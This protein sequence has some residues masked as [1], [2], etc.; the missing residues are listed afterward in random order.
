LGKR[1]HNAILVVS[2]PMSTYLERERAR[3]CQLIVNDP[4][5]FDGAIGGRAFVGAPRPFVLIEQDRNLFSAIRNN[6][7]SYFASNRISWWGGTR[8]TGHT[9]SSQVA[10]VNHMFAWRDDEAAATAV[11]RAISTEFVRALPIASDV[12]VAGF[13]QFEAVSDHQ[14]LNEGG[15]TRGTQCTSVD[16]MMYAER[17]DGSRWLVPIEWKYTEHYGNENKAAAGV[18][19]D[20]I[21]GKGAVRQRRYN[22]LIADSDQ[23]KSNDTAVY[24]FEPFYQL[25]RQTLLAEQIVRH[26]DCE[27]LQA[28]GFL[29]LHVIPPGNAALKAKTYR[30]SGLD[31]EAT[32]RRQLVDPSR[33]RIVDPKELLAPLAAFP[34]YSRLFEYLAA[35][36]WS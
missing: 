32:W 2:A 34:K 26:R 9:L 29:H 20:P 8:V 14:Y 33:Y 1:T 3:I 24:Y 6:A 23:L 36:Y 28:D 31:M 21:N 27:T 35:R 19:L 4:A 10:C 25:M 12:G 11:L 17:E 13:V 18:A 7:H 15:L 30:C 16:A 5:L 22:Q